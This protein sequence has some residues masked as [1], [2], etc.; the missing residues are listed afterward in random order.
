MNKFCILLFVALLLFGCQ[1]SKELNVSGFHINRPFEKISLT[2]L[3][4]YGIYNYESEL[5][6]VMDNEEEVLSHYQI[7]LPMKDLKEIRGGYKN[8]YFFYTHNRV[9]AIQQD[10]RKEIKVSNGLRC[11][12]RDSVYDYYMIAGR[13][14]NAWYEFGD[15]RKLKKNR[16]HYVYVD[17][18]IIMLMLNISYKDYKNF[19]EYPLNTFHIKRRGGIKQRTPYDGKK[20]PKED[21]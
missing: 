8:S 10:L 7:C 6:G 13:N 17:D 16:F 2:P 18:E 11:I 3:R 4:S 9:I 5:H 20:I 14:R 12:P 21:L 1:T 15:G 19:V